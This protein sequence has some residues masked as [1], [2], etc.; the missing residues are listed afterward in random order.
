[1]SLLRSGDLPRLH[2]HRVRPVHVNRLIALGWL[3]LAPPAQAVSGVELSGSFSYVLGP[4]LAVDP[5]QVSVTDVD[6]NGQWPGDIAPDRISGNAD[7]SSAALFASAREGG[8]PGTLGATAMV[9][10]LQEEIT[11]TGDPALPADKAT[12]YFA[13]RGL[14][15]TLLSQTGDILG[16]RVVTSIHAN[17]HVV[18]SDPTTQTVL[19]SA[20]AVSTHGAGHFFFTNHDGTAIVSTQELGPSLFEQPFASGPPADSI[21]TPRVGT[22]LNNNFGVEQVLAF[23]IDLRPGDRLDLDVTLMAAAHGVRGHYAY[24]E[25]ETI[26]LGI[27]LPTGMGFDSASGVF[28]TVPLPEPSATALLAVGVL[29]LA[30]RSSPSRSARRRP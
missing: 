13:Y 17:A 9:S 10:R 7:L 11:I 12:L 26:W 20:S 30:V 6:Y 25:A 23:D 19:G 24:A 2:R 4:H 8:V 28:L 15:E 21:S 3:L 14:S 5:V 27:T 1:M 18:H 16:G 29:S 22:S